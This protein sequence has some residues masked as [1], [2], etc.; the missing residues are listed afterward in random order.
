MCSKIYRCFDAAG[1]I[2]VSSYKK[3]IHNHGAVIVQ[4]GKIISTGCN[5]NSPSPSPE[6]GCYMHAEMDAL[7]KILDKLTDKSKR[8]MKLDIFVVKITIHP[9]GHESFGMSKPC[10]MCINLMKK[11]RIKRVFYSTGGDIIGNWTCEKISNI[12]TNYISSANRR[13]N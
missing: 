5:S 3:K 12:K 2:A 10:Q 1:S 9:N 6:Y 13:R 7:T 11:A 4:G 8:G